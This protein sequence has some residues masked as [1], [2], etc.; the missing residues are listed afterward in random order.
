MAGIAAINR[1]RK[2]CDPHLLTREY[3]PAAISANYIDI[4]GDNLCCMAD[5]FGRLATADILSANQHSRIYP[6]LGELNNPG[7]KILFLKVLQSQ[8]AIVISQKQD[9]KNNQAINKYAEERGTQNTQF[10]CQLISL[11]PAQAP[12]P[13]SSI[14]LANYSQLF[15]FTV[16]Q[17]NDLPVVCIAGLDQHGDNRISLY[18]LKG[19]GKGKLQTIS[20][21]KLKDV[22]KTLVLGSDTLLVLNTSSQA[23][24]YSLANIASPQL[25][26]TVTLIDEVINL[27][28]YDDLCAWSV[29]KESKCIIA[30]GDIK[31]FPKPTSELEA[32]N[33]LS[34]EALAMN[35]KYVLALGSNEKHSLVLP[36]SIDKNHLL[37]A[38]EP[39]KLQGYIE[40]NNSANKMVIGKDAAFISSG[41]A[42]MQVLSLNHGVWSANTYY[43]LQRLPIAGLIT[44][45]NYLILGGAELQLYDL[46]QAKRPKLLNTAKLNNTIKAIAAAGSYVLCLDKFGLTLRRIESPEAALIKFAIYS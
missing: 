10:V 14:S 20:T 39:V 31:A 46:S 24:L 2:K 3:W 21:F 40:S 33:L 9:N 12:K 11:A 35:N 5:E 15:A 32:K 19:K 29:Q 17:V 44:W 27:T 28:S 41:W 38:Q 43:G 16:G 36:F 25:T 22:P 23:T 34:V 7:H 37:R 1:G 26:R 18:S 45:S 13:I 8:S 4:F 30:L 42:G 6:I